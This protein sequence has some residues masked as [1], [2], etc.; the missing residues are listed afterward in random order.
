MT[1]TKATG[2]TNRAMV[3]KPTA[4]T[5]TVDLTAMKITTVMAAMDTAA[6]LDMV[7]EAMVA[8]LS[9]E[10]PAV[11]DP[12]HTIATLVAA[13]RIKTLLTLASANMAT[14]EMTVASLYTPCTA[15]RNVM[16]AV[17]ALKHVTV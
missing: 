9:A 16:A 15:T 5:T 2:M 6:A 12:P 4:M 1:T 13:M 17:L 7:R 14:P 3:T 8:L 10:V 11:M